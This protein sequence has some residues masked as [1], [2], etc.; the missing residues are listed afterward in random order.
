MGKANARHTCDGQSKNLDWS[1]TLSGHTKGENRADPARMR[2][3][4]IR[5]P[6]RSRQTRSI[7]TKTKIQSCQ[8]KR[9]MLCSEIFSPPPVIGKT[10]M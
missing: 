9:T 2:D 7:A 4:Q 3:D 10:S 5:H 6:V 1:R 8:A